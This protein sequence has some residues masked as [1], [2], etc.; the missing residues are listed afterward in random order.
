MTYTYT[1][2]ISQPWSVINRIEI[3]VATDYLLSWHHLIEINT[4]RLYLQDHYPNFS[5]ILET[6]STVIS[7]YRRIEIITE[8]FTSI[9][10][11]ELYESQL[12]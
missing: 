12:K 6:H 7:V 1:N 11:P 9:V 8:I 10:L 2:M 5:V 4:T 3:G